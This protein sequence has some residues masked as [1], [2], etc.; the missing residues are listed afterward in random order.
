MKSGANGSF[1]FRSVLGS[2]LL[3]SIQQL[4]GFSFVVI[5][6]ISAMDAFSNRIYPST[7]NILLSLLFLSLI[8]LIRAFTRRIVISAN[9]I[10]IGDAIGSF[11][12]FYREISI[13]EASQLFQRKAGR[14]IS[15]EIVNNDQFQVLT[16]VKANSLEAVLLVDKLK[17]TQDAGE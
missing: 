16:H 8:I 12:T 10:V 14:W 5:L 1:T 11:A 17:S 2:P 6:F 13:N 7:Q 9:N 15:I 4:C 3:W